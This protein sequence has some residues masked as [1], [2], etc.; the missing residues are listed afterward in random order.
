[1]LM[2]TDT[3]MPTKRKRK[4]ETQ[5][6]A[7]SDS[8]GYNKR[9]PQTQAAPTFERQSGPRHD[10]VSA[11][12]TGDH[13]AKPRKSHKKSPAQEALLKFL[14]EY[15][16]QNDGLNPTYQVMADAFG[17]SKEA[18]YQT[19]LRMES[20]GLVHR[21]GKRRLRLGPKPQVDEYDP[22]KTGIQARS[23]RVDV[24]RRETIQ[25]LYRQQRGLCWWCSVELLGIYEI[26]HRVPL[27]MGGTNEIGNLCLSC[28]DCNHSK[29]D[30]LPWEFNGRLL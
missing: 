3:T 11:M 1:M 22:E 4:A 9:Q 26:D 27:A 25:T 29:S 20:R 16:T 6:L 21:D 8:P 19:V 30:K 10:G 15:K 18:I 17:V 28:I 24:R 7:Q 13:I 23:E 14:T 5:E 12:S 2:T